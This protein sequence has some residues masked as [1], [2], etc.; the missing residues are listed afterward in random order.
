MGIEYRLRVPAQSRESVARALDEQ[1]QSL[2]RSVDPTAGDAFPN[3]IV[4]ADEDG[5]YVCDTLTDSTV[6]ALVIR[7]IVDL[8]LLHSPSVTIINE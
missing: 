2:I 3:A 4:K 5:V 7:G 6:A 1:L 8:M